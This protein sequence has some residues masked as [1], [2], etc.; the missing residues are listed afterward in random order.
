MSAATIYTIGHGNE[1]F[2]DMERRLAM[3]HVQTIVDVRSDPFSRYAPDF[4]KHEL[5]SIAAEAGIGYR[6][7]GDRLG[8]RPADPELLTEGR[9]DPTKVRASAGFASGI[10]ELTAV[11]RTSRVAVM[12]AELDHRHCH[13][14]T[15]ITPTLEEEGWRVLHIDAEGAA[16]SHQP[17]LG[18]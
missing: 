15:W 17:E 7:L 4:A 9:P 6:W 8:G 14:T 13:R 5:E 1:T 16:V 10:A 11:A 2:A 12:C 18:L 3:H